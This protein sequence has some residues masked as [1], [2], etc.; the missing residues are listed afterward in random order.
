MKNIRTFPIIMLGS[1]LLLWAGFLRAGEDLNAMVPGDSGGVQALLERKQKQIENLKRQLS[2]REDIITVLERE[3]QS[4]D[5]KIEALRTLFDNKDAQLEQKEK[6]LSFQISLGK[7]Q[8]QQILR[9]RE[10]V[11]GQKK[12]IQELTELSGLQP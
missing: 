9:F 5:T 7:F 1:I 4:R 3:I 2:S 8:E 11:R 6:L 12:Q 10:I